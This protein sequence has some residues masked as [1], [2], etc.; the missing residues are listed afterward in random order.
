MYFVS[1][2][3]GLSITSR[4]LFSQVVSA[5]GTINVGAG[6]GESFG[7]CTHVV[8]DVGAGADADA[9]ANVEKNMII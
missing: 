7:A 6:V 4:I 3:L 5:I 2:V 9:D 1:Y 8:V